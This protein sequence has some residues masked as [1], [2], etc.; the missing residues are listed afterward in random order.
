MLDD[1]GLQLLALL[2]SLPHFEFFQ[3][4]M[5]KTDWH[6]LNGVQLQVENVSDFQKLIGQQ[7]MLPCI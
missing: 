6:L 4:Q 1:F 5:E 3:V 7:D 2:R